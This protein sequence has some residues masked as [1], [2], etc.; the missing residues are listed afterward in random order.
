MDN[1]SRH[2]CQLQKSVFCSY[3]L[4]PPTMIKGLI[5][6]AAMLSIATHSYYVFI[7][8]H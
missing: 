1:R 4:P 6:T 8:H 3:D 5:K 7:L 2:W